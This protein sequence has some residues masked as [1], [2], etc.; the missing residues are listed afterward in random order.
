MSLKLKEK[1]YKKLL[2][3]VISISKEAGKK[4]LKHQKKLDTL[5]ISYKDAQ[6]AVSEA[7][8]QTEKFIIKKLLKLLP[9]SEILGE[10]SAF[11]SFGGK[12]EFYQ[13]F[14]NKDLVWVIDPLDGTHNFLQGMDYFAVCIAL[15][16][17]GVPVIG[18]VHRPSTNETYFARKNQGTFIQKADKRAKKISPLKNKKEL[19]QGMM[20]TG[21]ATEKG[22]VL[23]REF[24]LFYQM[25]GK[26]RGIRRMGS[27]ALDLCLVAQ[28]TFD[29]FWERGLAPWDVAAAG[30]IC[31]EA[32]VKVTNYNGEAFHPFQETIFAARMPFYEKVSPILGQNE[33]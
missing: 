27:A 22:E 9:E 32:G 31:K 18:V 7:D 20:V 26:S 8:I 12:C 33:K 4:L 5:N 3:E 16:K 29:C 30:I 24:D 17:K 13:E 25:M 23:D 10:E 14:K 2:T 21:F 28:G 11:E 19:R 1:E 6:G 15:V